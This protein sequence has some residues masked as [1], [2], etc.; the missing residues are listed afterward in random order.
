MTTVHDPCRVHLSHIHHLANG[1]QR[2]SHGTPHLRDHSASRS[3]SQFHRLRGYFSKES[4]DAL[5]DR[6]ALDHTIELELRAKT[7][8]TKVY[9]LSPN[10][11]MEVDAFI[12]RI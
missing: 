11:Q 9:L 7:S 5:P 6:Q 4:F 10:E 3:L 8:S 12:E 1:W 2:H